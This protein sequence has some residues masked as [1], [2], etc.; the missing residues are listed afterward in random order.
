MQPTEIKQLTDYL[1]VRISEG[2]YYTA[3]ARQKLREQLK[4]NAA[5]DD[6]RKIAVGRELAAEKALATKIVRLGSRCV[7]ML[8]VFDVTRSAPERANS[9]K[10]HCEKDALIVALEKAVRVIMQQEEESQKR[11][12]VL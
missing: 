4:D 6:T 1:T 10:S 12:G 8:T 9:T 7:V 5:G 2:I 11:A 3:V